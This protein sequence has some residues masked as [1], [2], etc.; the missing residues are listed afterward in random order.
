MITRFLVKRIVKWVLRI[1]IALLALVLLAVGIFFL[2][3]RIMYSDFY[4]VAE[5]GM[6]A[7]GLWNGY[8]SQ[9]FDYYEA[10]GVYL[11]C[12]YDKSGDASSIYIMNGE[13][14]TQVELKNADGTDYTGHTGGIDTYGP[15]IY[16]T[17]AKGCDLFLVDDVFDGDGKATVAGE[18]KTINDPAYCTVR[19]DLLYAGSFYDTGKYETPMEHRFTTPAGDRNT[20]IISVYRLDPTTGKAVSEV[21]EVVIS[22]TS[23]VQGMTFINDSTMV[24]SSS[25]G[26]STSLIRFY[27]LNKMEANGTTLKV[28]EVDVPVWFLDSS[29]LVETVEAPPMAEEI[30]YHDGKLW[31]LT[32]SA[33]MKYIFGKFTSGNHIYGL[34]LPASVAALQ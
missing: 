34:P 1:L 33:S 9:G 29:A 28:G 8:V 31:I 3:D 32:E 15:Y 17:G 21:P 6:K 16:I 24:L 14:Q 11:S 27:D 5:K 2:R 13:E 25:Y 18:I 4:D 12:G 26:L 30:V 23:Q 7:P 22:T 20:A 19:G 10:R